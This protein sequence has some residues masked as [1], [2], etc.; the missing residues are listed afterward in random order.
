M[1]WHIEVR[2]LGHWAAVSGSSGKPY[3]YLSAEDA[4]GG[5]RRFY[6]D[7]T[8]MDRLDKTSKYVRIKDVTTGK[9]DHVWRHA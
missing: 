3:E 4:A 6:P 8:R 2:V 7:L 1:T 5:A 9:V